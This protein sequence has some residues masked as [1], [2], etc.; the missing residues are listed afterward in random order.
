MHGESWAPGAGMLW[1][2][3]GCHLGGWC[4]GQHENPAFAGRWNGGGTA[5]VWCCLLMACFAHLGLF[6]LPD[7]HFPWHLLFLSFLSLFLVTSIPS[8]FLV[9]PLPGGQANRRKPL[10]SGGGGGDINRM[11]RE[12]GMESYLGVNSGCRPPQTV[13]I[14]SSGTWVLLDLWCR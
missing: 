5:C 7:L 3:C 9:S 1:C 11:S 6:M 4:E 13:R 10:G 12:L 14:H 2:W 8:P